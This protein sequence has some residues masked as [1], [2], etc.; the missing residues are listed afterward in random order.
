MLLPVKT[1]PE[2]RIETQPTTFGGGSE[3]TAVVLQP[4]YLP[5]LGCFAQMQRCDVFIVYDN[6][7]FD[8]HGWRNRNRIKT[9]QGECWLTVPVLTRGRDKPLIRDV[10][11]NTAERWRAKHLKTVRQSYARAPYFEDHIGWLE[12]IWSREWMS[13]LDLNMECLQKLCEALGLKR[14]IRLASEFDTSGDSIERLVQICRAV[15]ADVFYEGGAG[16]D[17]IDDARFERAGIRIEYQDYRH[18]VYSQLHGDFLPYL[19]V[20][21]LLMNCGGQSL[22]ILS[23]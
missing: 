11:I 8:K 21:D 6:V 1:T 5:W 7:Q 19:S 20:V 2:D 13:L 17:Y 18:P 12:A 16:R 9:P 14:E 23:Q 4:S 15:D 22:E 3:R 10:E